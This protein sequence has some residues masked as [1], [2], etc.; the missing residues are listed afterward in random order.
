M[1]LTALELTL[2]TTEVLG[3]TLTNARLS[4]ISV[5]EAPPMERDDRFHFSDGSVRVLMQAYVNGFP[6][7]LSG[8][9]VG[10]PQG[11]LSPAG[12]QLSLTDLR[13]ELEDSVISAALEIAIHGQYDARRPNAQITHVTAPTSCA[14][15]VALLATS[16]DDDQDPLT[17]T[18]WI[19]DVG[20]FDGPL[21]EVVLPAGEHDLMLT[22]FDP[23]GLFDS[24]T[25][26][27]ARRCR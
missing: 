11:R 19:R 27:Y 15:P 1:Q 18:W 7:V 20:T 25:L 4:V 23:S 10:T 26:R 14:D 2:S 17:H 9:N 8:W 12:D 16:W 13:F 6:L 24:E 22:S 3:M 21:V 5:A